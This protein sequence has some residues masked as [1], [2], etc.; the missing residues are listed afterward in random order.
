MTIYVVS[1]G[2]DHSKIIS[3][4][5]NVELL[6]EGLPHNHATMAGDY[7]E[8]DGYDKDGVWRWG[9]KLG[10]VETEGFDER[11]FPLTQAKSTST[12][13]HEGYDKPVQFELL[14]ERWSANWFEV[15]YFEK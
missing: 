2:N 8:G 10:D 1:Y 13:Y 9:W 7:L 4:Y 6:H 14:V 3:V 11:S 15:H 12:W 5:D